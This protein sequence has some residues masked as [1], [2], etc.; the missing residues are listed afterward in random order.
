MGHKY[1][2]THIQKLKSGDSIPKSPLKGFT[3]ELP[4][5]LRKYVDILGPFPKQSLEALS[6]L[7]LSDSEIARYHTIPRR[8]VSELRTIWHIAG[9]A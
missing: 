1:I 6:D 3:Q 9:H 8:C 2:Q 7:G 5:Q 4:S